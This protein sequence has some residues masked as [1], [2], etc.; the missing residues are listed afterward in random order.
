MTRRTLLVLAFALPALH[1]AP[2]RAH[3][4]GLSHGTWTARGDGLDF[5][6]RLRADELRAA[7]PELAP[8]ADEQSLALVFLG[9]VEVSRRGAACT[10]RPGPAR[11]VAP[12]GLELHASFRCPVAGGP[13][14]VRLPI[15]SRLPPGHVHL[16]RMESDGL[17]EERVADARQ[18]RLELAGRP[19]GLRHASSFVALGVEHILTGWDHLAFLLAL[20]LA[21][22]RLGDVLRSLTAFTA[23]HALTLALGVLGV[24]RP[25]GE[26]VEPIIAASIV[27]VAAANLVD[28]RRGRL[29]GRPRW[30][31]AFAFGLVHGFGFAGALG[32]L[33]LSGGD[34]A[35]A[36]GSFNVGVEMGQAPVALAAVPVLR[37]LRSS[38]RAALPALS[39]G[40]AAV[41]AAGLFWLAERLPW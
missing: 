27:W 8:S 15:L 38:P 24:A 41:A 13:T 30:P 18:P 34:L 12:D 6:V 26:I 40:S 31:L 23:A 17:V 37:R 3:Q 33:R 10:G 22:V 35:L 7:A 20:L 2:A 5:A 11:T 36:L 14:E 19:A 29:S 1:P 28:L 39:A 4:A 9:G 25:P 16:A 21:A 32:E